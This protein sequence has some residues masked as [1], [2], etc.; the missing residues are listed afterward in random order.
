[1]AESSLK[2]P[3][4]SRIISRILPPA[5]RLWLSSQLDHVE[6]LVFKIE[7][8]DRDILSGHIP[9]VSLS[10]EKAVYQGVH[11]SQAAVTAQT[12]RV[13]LGQVI[14]R[15]PLRLLAPFP[16]SGNVLLTTADFN[17]SLQSALLG[18][19]LYDFLHRL[20]HAQPEAAQLQHILDRLPRRTVLPQYQPTADIGVESIRLHLIPSPGETVP[21]IAISTQLAIRDGHR[22]CLENPHWLTDTKSASATPLP[23]L[24]GFEIDLGP[25]VTLTACELKADHM[26]LNGTIRV[27]P[28]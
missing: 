11:L 22:L 21:A 24:H 8:R 5:I 6:N 15:Q 20:V 23:A 28:G 19:G 13:N 2:Q 7:G 17:Q 27:L 26:I 14:R 3:G 1:M 4:G 18:E 9:E 16:V 25:E 12:I 10:A